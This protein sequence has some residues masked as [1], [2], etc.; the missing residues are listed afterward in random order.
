MTDTTATVISGRANML[1]LRI[2][3]VESAMRLEL[4]TGMKMTRHANPFEIAR[5]YL[6]TTTRSKQKV[7]DLFVAAMPAL[8]AAC[9]EHATK[10]E[11]LQPDAV[12]QMSDTLTGIQLGKDATTT[13][14]PYGDEEQP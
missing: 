6:K 14:D 2:S 7:Y 9:S 12:Q 1:A 11:P 5:L 10:D 8:L 13:V 3:M 4:K